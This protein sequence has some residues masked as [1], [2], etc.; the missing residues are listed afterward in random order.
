M[1]KIPNEWMNAFIPC[2]LSVVFP[3]VFV[4]LF[5]LPNVTTCYGKFPPIVIPYWLTSYIISTLNKE[6]LSS[7]RVFASLNLTWIYNTRI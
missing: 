2:V 7:D 6:I 5:F 1:W 4:F 3:S